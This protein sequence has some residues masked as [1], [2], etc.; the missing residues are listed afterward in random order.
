MTTVYTPGQCLGTSDLF[1]SS[2]CQTELVPESLYYGVEMT[3]NG[4]VYQLF[5]NYNNSTNH[6]QSLVGRQVYLCHE[7]LRSSSKSSTSTSS[8]HAS[9]ARF[10]TSMRGYCTLRAS[11]TRWSVRWKTRTMPAHCGSSWR[12]LWSL[13]CPSRCTLM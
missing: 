5:S 12:R 3:C 13:P 8:A 6:R 11:T 2:R 10:P 1:S 7:P 9:D 4:N